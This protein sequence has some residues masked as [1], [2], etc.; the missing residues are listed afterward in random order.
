MRPAQGDGLEL[1]KPFVMK[2]LVEQ[3][4]T[5]NIKTAK[6]MV[7]RLQP[8]VWD[9][10]DEVI[11]DHPILLNRAPTLHRL[12]IQ[13]FEPVLV[14]GKA[15]QIHPLV[16]AAFNADFD[17]DQMAVHVPL[18]AAAQAEA[19]ILMMS[20]QNLFSP[21]H[22]RPLVTPTYDIV[23]GCYYLTQESQFGRDD[24]RLFGSVDEALMAHDLGQQDLHTR[25]QVRLD[26]MVLQANGP[27]GAV[28]LEEELD[29]QLRRRIAEAY[30]LPA[31]ALALRQGYRIAVEEGWGA[32]LA[33]PA[34]GEEA[35]EAGGNGARPPEEGARGP[36]G[37]LV[38]AAG[39]A[40]EAAC[41]GEAL[42]S[43]QAEALERVL[44][45]AWGRGLAGRLQSEVQEMRRQL[46]EV[47]ELFQELEGVLAQAL[48]EGQ[49][50]AGTTVEFRVERRLRE[51]TVGR[52][53]FNELLPLDLRYI[54]R[55][56]DRKE[57]Q[58]I[59]Q[60]CHRRHGQERTVQLLDQLKAVGFKFATLSGVSIAVTDLD[61]PAMRDQI[62]AETEAQVEQ[63]NRR[64][65]DGIITAGERESEVTRLWNEA[66]DRVFDAITKNISK[67]NPVSMMAD[68]GARGNKRQITQ[69]A[70][71]RGLMA[72][73]FGRLIEDL[74]IVHNFREGL[75][76]LEYFISTHGARKGLADTALRTADAGYLTRRLVDVSQDV[77]VRGHDCGTINGITVDTIWEV[78]R[79]CDEC[80]TL[81]PHVGKF[82][83]ACGARLSEDLQIVESLSERIAGRIASEPIY[84]Y[85]PRTC[86]RCGAIAHHAHPFCQSCGERLAEEAV[87]SGEILVDEQQEIEDKMAEFLEKERLTEEVSIRSPLTCDMR[88]GIC[89]LCYGRDLSTKRL[90]E[91]GEAVGII[92]AQSIGEPGTQLTMRTFH[93][94]GVAGTGTLTGVAD[95]KKKKQDMIRQLHQDIRQGFVTLDELGTGERERN[96][97]IQDMLKV[98]EEPVRG[99]LRVVEL[100]EARRPKGQAITS[101]VDGVV[102]D[103][104]RKGLRK[105]IIHSEQPITAPESIF[106]DA[107][108][109]EEV[110]RPGTEEVIA[111]RGVAVTKRVLQVLEE[112]GVTH[113]RIQK[114]YLV[115]YRGYL[116]VRKGQQVAAGDR[117]TE[118]PLNPQEV[119]EMKGVS[120]VRD[121]LVREIQ[122]VYREQ[123]VEINDKHVEVIVRQMLKKRE[124][125]DGGDTD[126]LPG[127]KVDRWTFEEENARV[128]ARGG[129]EATANWILLGITE[130]SLAT[131]S[132]LSAASFQKTTRV[133]TE[134]ATQGKEDPLVGLKE[135]VIIGRLIPAGTGMPI[136]RQT[137]IEAAWEGYE[138]RGEELPE[139]RAVDLEEEE[140]Q[141]RVDEEMKELA[142]FTGLEEDFSDL[143][144]E[145][146]RPRPSR[147][148]PSLLEEEEEE[149]EGEEGFDLEDTSDASIIEGE[150]E[151]DE[152]VPEPD[153]IYD[154]TSEWADE[155][156]LE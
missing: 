114:E 53:I 56:V 10:L 41:R 70:G 149:E 140:E 108:L 36:L 39:E 82:C 52:V 134:A 145:A 27:E 127:Q 74:P 95:V 133:L 35:A 54:D 9:A 122:K 151:I 42:N 81:I 28:E 7:D 5:T 91:I 60:E 84:A 51:I 137:R 89:S 16:C 2:R 156:D 153:S 100:F 102:A 47:Q 78:P 116:E 17:G 19:R 14:D 124:V 46:R 80:L 98:L 44:G 83:H 32:A 68:S 33:A 120:G 144:E 22:G 8:E 61:V 45:A 29:L 117:L 72:D 97:A 73:P 67:F 129:R 11:Q 121:Y 57:L 147:A 130:A 30:E 107:V 62:I 49:L 71:M 13:A 86:E 110:L 106:K 87:E 85:Q 90:V 43:A 131:D 12:G 101:D 141:A 112:A 55:V 4:H 103:I 115:P 59:I 26:E 93:T 21:A 20:T 125:I 75:N 113:I 126:L 92:A 40:L 64:F 119:L 132:F 76:V 24:L 99:L 105:V 150:E 37:A 139:L 23:L 34:A 50:P 136:Y 109:A 3:G 148:T 58:R 118:G 1:F 143:T 66:S 63:L 88:Q 135:N 96:K 142:G 94:G 31:G 77:I 65:R 69:L 18:S 104:S 123:G 25:V 6:R 152:E 38:A 154:Q 111:H 48:R 138:G 15:I 146:R 128:R 155:E 79:R